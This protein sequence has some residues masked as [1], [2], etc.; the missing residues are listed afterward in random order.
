ME[1]INLEQLAGWAAD[2]LVE[3]RVARLGL[4]DDEGHPRV[5]PVTFVLHDTRLWTAVDRKPKRVPE[6]EPARVGFLRRNPRA[7][8]T[9]DRYDDD[10]S[11][12]AWVQVLGDVTVLEVGDEPDALAALTAKYPQYGRERPPGP[13]LRIDPLRVLSWS[14]ADAG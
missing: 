10:W 13:L 3:A 7:A 12:L 9:V 6:R 8:L 4:V 2:L 5:L 11:R 14:A 1:R